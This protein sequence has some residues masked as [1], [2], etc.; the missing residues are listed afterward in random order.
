MGGGGA[1][2]LDLVGAAW[3]GDEAAVAAAVAAG[4]DLDREA[5]GMTPLVAAAEGG[6]LAALRTL[7][8]AGAD[9]NRETR[10]GNT[11]LRA[12]V[13]LG[14]GEVLGAADRTGPPGP[15]PR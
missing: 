14:D 3:E 4:A 8:E 7:L 9:P 5:R 11:P 13:V 12:A 15:A 6:H 10:T 1:E 2:G